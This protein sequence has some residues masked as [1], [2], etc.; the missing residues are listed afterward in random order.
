M[1]I[2]VPTST[3]TPPAASQGSSQWLPWLALALMAAVY[4][5]TV[6]W[7]V[8]RWTISVWQNAHGLLIPPVVAWF[9]W[10]ELKRFP[11]EPITDPGV[12]GLGLIGAGLGLHIVD[13]G[14][15][16]QLLSAA[17]IVVVIPGLSLVFLGRARTAAVAFPL[18][19]LA[20]MLPIPLALTERLHMLLRHV[21]AGAAAAIVPVLGIPV[22]AEQT[23]LHI[24]NAT[25]EVADACSGFSTLYAAMATAFLVAYTAPNWRRRVLVL[26]CAAPIAIVANVIRVVL[27]VVLVYWQGSDVLATSLHSISGMF[28]F[29]LALPVI[30]WLG[31]TGRREPVAAS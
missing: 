27:L 10:Q 16:T 30:F 4:A 24:A 8:D 9:C 13:A 1:S 25:L 5:P 22:Y 2:E 23:T 26:A 6:A 29:A 28:T 12:A 31:G 20:F 15:G 18:V 14:L 3:P 17:S 19:F 21:A 7:L 11:R